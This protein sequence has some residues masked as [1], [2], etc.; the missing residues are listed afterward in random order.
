[1]LSYVSVSASARGPCAPFA[2]LLTSCVRRAIFLDL[3]HFLRKLLRE[4]RS[5]QGC[6]WSARLVTTS[7]LEYHI[8]CF[9][10]ATYHPIWHIIM[11]TLYANPST[12]A[13]CYFDARHQTA[14]AGLWAILMILSP[15]I[16][17]IR[18]TG[19]ICFSVSLFELITQC[20]VFTFYVKHKCSCSVW[21]ISSV[22]S[23]SEWNLKAWVCSEWK[24]CACMVG[25][26]SVFDK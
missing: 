23:L 6:D 2:R 5:L 8:S 19:L 26:F 12:G 1:M 10:T 20:F 14:D 16:R 22:A 15:D 4:P 7:C 24:M 18:P 17:S 21:N 3:R 25:L 9:H 13:K 11:R